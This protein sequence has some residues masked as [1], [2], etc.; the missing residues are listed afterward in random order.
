MSITFDVSPFWKPR[1]LSLEQSEKKM[2]K[3]AEKAIR[4]KT[5]EQAEKILREISLQNFPTPIE[6]SN[7]VFERGKRD[8][9]TEDAH[10]LLYLKKGLLAGVCDGHGGRRVADYLCDQFLKRFVDELEMADYNVH[11]VFEKIFYETAQE[12]A[13]EVAWEKQG[14]VAVVC[15]IEKETGRVYTATLGDCE[16]IIYREMW[17]Q[18][19]PISLSCDRKWNKLSEACRAAYAFEK[20]GSKDRAQK[21]ITKW[22]NSDQPKWLRF[23][24]PYG[25]N[26]SRSIGDVRW[27][28]LPSKESKYQ[29]RFP[30]T[31]PK[32]KITMNY[33]KS[34]DRLILASDGLKDLPEED[35]VKEIEEFKGNNL[36]R[37]LGGFASKRGQEDDIT[38]LVIAIQ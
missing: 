35:V 38:V 25:I 26:V 34:G 28:Q 20:L 2:Q 14:A 7:S 29:K 22:I 36:A 30:A 18:L 6:F 11:Q 5:P 8:R 4:E 19:W 37:H 23:P 24:G 16:A 3:N 12:V 17:G 27:M 9:E 15:F 21:A 10:F 1:E 33:L 32:P 13:Q 31:T